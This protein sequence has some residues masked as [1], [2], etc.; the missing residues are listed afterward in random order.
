MSDLPEKCHCGE[1]MHL[2]PGQ[3]FLYKAMLPRWGT[4]KKV[5]VLGGK[6]YSIPVYYIIVHGLK[7]VDISTLGFPEIK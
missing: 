2:S 6:T 1:K 4:H 5:K 3:L 7:A